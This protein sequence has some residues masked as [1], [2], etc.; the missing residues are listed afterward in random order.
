MKSVFD[1]EVKNNHHYIMENGIV[2]HNIGPIYVASMLLVMGKRKLK[3]DEEGN[4]VMEV[5]GQ[6]LNV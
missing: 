1:I 5:L 6:I 3:E 4:K 2:S